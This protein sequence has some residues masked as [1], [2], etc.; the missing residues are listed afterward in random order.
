MHDI[1][2]RE[3]RIVDTVDIL[4]DDMVDFTSRLVAEPS[5]LGNE[6][7]VLEVMENEFEKL[8]FSAERVSID[9]VLLKKHPG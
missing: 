5:T 1:D 4:A 3:K 2:K 7:S 6:M 8:G 9:P